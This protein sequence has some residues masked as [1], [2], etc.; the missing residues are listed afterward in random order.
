MALLG[1]KALWDASK[2][3][4]GINAVG[5]GITALTRTHKIT[6]LV[7]V[8]YIFLRVHSLE[9]DTHNE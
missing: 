7:G 6:D 8:G 1:Y 4:I 2:L 3:M 9:Q 5:F